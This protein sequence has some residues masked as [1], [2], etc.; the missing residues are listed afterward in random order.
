MIRTTGWS[1]LFVL[2]LAPTIS[3]QNLQILSIAPAP[4]Q[5]HVAVGANV[6]IQFDDTIAAASMTPAALILRGRQGGLLDAGLSGG[7]TTTVTA[8]PLSDFLPGDVISLTLT[9][10]LLSESGHSLARAMMIE[11][12]WCWLRFQ[13]HSELSQWF[14]QRFGP[15]GK[16]SR[17]IGIVALARRLLVA[18]W[19]YLEHGVVPKGAILTTPR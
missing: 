3:A 13:P 5:N 9:T 19:R 15:G 2:G 16:R 7:G 4:A 14:E 17:R 10:A 18:L 11:L 6:V 1:L 12:A 8:D